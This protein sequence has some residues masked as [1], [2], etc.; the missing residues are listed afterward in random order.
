MLQKELKEHSL[1]WSK[2][3][4]KEISDRIGMAET[5]VYKWWWDQ[6]RK[7][8]KRHRL[9]GQTQ[10]EYEDQEGT[11]A[12]LYLPAVDEFGGYSSRLRKGDSDPNVL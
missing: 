5:Q 6:T 8:V 3:K 4:I 12:E 2:E 10:G 1:L 9:E 11:I 7:R